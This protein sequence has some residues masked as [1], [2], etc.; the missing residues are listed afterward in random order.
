MTTLIES[1]LFNVY[2]NYNECNLTWWRTTDS[3]SD[4][5]VTSGCWRSLRGSWLLFRFE[6]MCP[7]SKF[8][9]NYSL[10]SSAESVSLETYQT[11]VWN[12]AS[13]VAG[14]YSPN[15]PVY[16]KNKV[17]FYKHVI[18]SAHM[19]IIN[20]G[21]L[22]CLLCSLSCFNPNSILYKLYCFNKKYISI[23]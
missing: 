2:N 13:S 3:R 7:E 18:I 17:Q 20:Y 23:I 8:H 22:I 5:I 14:T 4:S 6:K 21:K 15:N 10:P 1:N 11:P 9:S 12:P 19:Q 16:R